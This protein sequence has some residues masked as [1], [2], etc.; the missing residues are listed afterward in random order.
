MAK[1]FISYKRVNK[2]RVI[3]LKNQIYNALHED[4]WIDTEGIMS[5]EYFIN[6][7]ISAINQADILLF[8]YSHAHTLIKDYDKDWTIRELFFA[9]KKNK[10][11]I[12]LNIDKTPLTDWFLMMFGT[13]QQIDATSDVEVQK[14]IKDL[15]IWLG[16]D[17]DTTLYNDDIHSE[18]NTTTL[19]NVDGFD[20]GYDLA[21]FVIHKLRGQ[22]IPEQESMMEQKMNELG[23]DPKLLMDK[24]SH[25][26][27]IERLNDCAY[28]LGVQFGKI[29]E[30]CV[31]L[32]VLFVLSVIAKRSHI[33]EEFGHFYDKAL[34]ITCRQLNFDTNLTKRLIKSNDE[35]MESMMEELKNALYMLE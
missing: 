35:E 16:K 3:S 15:A 32:G 6:V 23:L 7:I 9:Q 31:C 10:R 22:T 17:I 27:M 1:I 19:S 11:I 21:L 5:D 33:S 25:E 24:V 26:N 4:C 13:K 8:M 18:S 34:V 2:K 28:N 14:L 29:I 20:V 12:F 30:N